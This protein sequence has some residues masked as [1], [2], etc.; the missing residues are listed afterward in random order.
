MR[1]SK[2]FTIGIILAVAF[3]A[4]LPGPQNP[5]QE[6]EDVKPA[7]LSLI[8]KDLLVQ[9]I[10]KLDPP[11][12]NIFMPGSAPAQDIES[13]EEMIEGGQMLPQEAEAVQAEV[14]AIQAF[15]LR[16]IGY[17]KTQQKITALILFQGEA[18]AVDVGEEIVNGLS[19]SEVTPEAITVLGPDQEPLTFPL[20]G[21]SQ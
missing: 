13:R 18:L 20:E 8:R 4:A 15:G 1:F 2:L 17:V 5:V 12:R 3:G 6:K 16:Y 9:E 19:V 11:R 7:A 10:K 21:D 14:P